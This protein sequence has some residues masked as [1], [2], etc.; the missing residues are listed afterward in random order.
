MVGPAIWLERAGDL[1]DLLRLR[2]D[3]GVDQADAEAPGALGQRLGDQLSHT[4]T[5]SAAVAVRLAS[6][7]ATALTGWLPTSET[8]LTE[9]FAAWTAARYSPMPRQLPLEAVEVE[10]RRRARIDVEHLVGDRGGRHAAE[11]DDHRR[12]ALPDGALGERIDDEGAV[13]VAVLLDEP[14]ANEHAGGVDDPRRLASSE[15]ADGDDPVADHGDVRP[16]P[17]A[18]GAVEDAAVGYQEIV[19]FASSRGNPGFPIR[20]SAVY[21]PACRPA[22]APSGDQTGLL[23]RPRATVVLSGAKDLG[24]GRLDLDRA[25]TSPTPGPSLRSGRH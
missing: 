23:G 10:Q 17:G 15:M 25:S 9:G 20:L 14:G 8:T 24:R 19:H 11:A 16:V 1:D 22:R 2:E 7:M 5:R 13:G 3:G 18:P 4:Y 12:H 21:T 6:P